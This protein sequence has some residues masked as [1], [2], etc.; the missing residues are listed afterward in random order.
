MFKGRSRYG[1]ETKRAL[2]CSEPGPSSAMG[3]N[4]VVLPMI[5]EY[6]ARLESRAEKYLGL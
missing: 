5:L 2:S 4:G 6:E 3:G 1:S